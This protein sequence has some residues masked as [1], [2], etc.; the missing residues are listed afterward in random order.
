MGLIYLDA[1]LLIYLVE[2]HPRW[3]DVV[4]K[5]MAN[6]SK[7]QFGISSLVKFECLVGPA[8]RG[9]SVLERA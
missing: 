5:A 4:A 2:R 8:N 1:C 9:D 3:G 6:A 7:S